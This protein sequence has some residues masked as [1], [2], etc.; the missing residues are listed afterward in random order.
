MS[1]NLIE[2][3][4]QLQDPRDEKNRRY[5]LEEILFLCVS[6]VVSGA[7]GWEAIERFGQAKLDWLRRFLPMTHGIPSHDTI[8]WL[9][10]RLSPKRFQCC[11]VEWV[12]S[13]SQDTQGEIISIDGKTARRSYDTNR[14]LGAIHMISAW[15]TAN[16]LSLGQVATDAKSNE[17]TAIPTLLDLLEIKGGIVTIDAMGCQTAI[18]EKI[19]D[20]GADYVLAVKG[21]QGTLHEAI[22]D[23]FT[24]ARSL[25]FAAVPF[26]FTE[27]TD[28]AHGRLEQRRYWLT[29]DLSTLPNPQR[30]K[31]LSAIGMVECTRQINDR[32][33]VEHRYYILSFKQDVNR[34]AQAVRCHWGVENKLHWVLDVTFRED[35][36]RIRRGHAPANFNTIRQ[37][38]LNLL[39]REPSKISIKQKRFEAALNDTFRSKV[40]F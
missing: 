8:A 23:Y 18:A 11:F 20:Q 34:F 27:E 22:D 38:C 28:K 5:P 39:R 37:T 7:E 19:I 40:M 13:L 2:C 12:Q 31:Q 15:A 30:W 36:S 26:E 21:N 14:S 6:A 25:D 32:V 4:S 29:S 1:S 3:F 35:E 9:M 10:A 24:T 33:S 16:Q 17:I